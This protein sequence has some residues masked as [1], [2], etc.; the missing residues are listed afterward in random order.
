M[1]FDCD[2]IETEK[3]F[4][5]MEKKFTVYGIVIDQ[6]DNNKGYHFFANVDTDANL[7]KAFYID[8]GLMGENSD[9]YD[10]KIRKIFDLAVDYHLFVT[11][12]ALSVL[13]DT[14]GGITV[15][16]KKADGEAALELLKDGQ[17]MEVAEGVANALSSSGKSLMLQIPGLLSALKDTYSTDMPLM[18]VIKTAIG[19]IGDLKKWKADFNEVRKD[20]VNQAAA[21]AVL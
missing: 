8:R 18:D 12:N 17:L 9:Q 19:E 2:N 1:C 11:S 13:V 15:K 21:L 6:T 14:L 5:D 7:A 20:N 4:D 3:E 16:G 10:A